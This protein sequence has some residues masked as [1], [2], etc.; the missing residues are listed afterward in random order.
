MRK[1]LQHVIRHDL[2]DKRA[3]IRRDKAAGRG[4]LN[5]ETLEGRTLLAGGLVVGP[6]E[7]LSHAVGDQAETAIAINPTNP[8]NIVA[9]SNEV[10]ASTGLFEGISNDGGLTWL[11]KNVATGSDGLQAACCD[12]SLAF[13]RFGNLFLTYIT[14]DVSTAVVALSTDG[15]QTFKAIESVGAQDQPK[16]ATGPGNLAG[17]QSV[18]IEYLDSSGNIAAVSANTS[19]LGK[20][21]AFTSVEEAPGLGGNFGKLSIGPKGQVMLTYQDNT[22][23]GGPSSIFVN[24]DPDGVGGSGFGPSIRVTGTNVG[25]FDYITAQPNRSIDAE[26]GLAY[27]NSGGAHNGRVYMV[28]TD[29]A[30]AGLN[31]PT[32]A[33]SNTF[34]L[35]RYSDDNGTTW[36]NPLRV[37]DNPTKNSE[38][39]PRIAVDPVTG[40]VGFSW[41]DCRHDLG[42]GGAGDTDGKPNDQPEFFATV[43]LDGGLTF[44][45]NVQ[46]SA[47]PSDALIAAGGSGDNGFDFGDYTGLSFYNNVLRPVWADNSPQLPGIP[48]RPNLDIASAPVNVE[49]LSVTPQPFTPTENKLFTGTVATFKD[50]SHPGSPASNYVAQINWGDGTVTNGAVQSLGVDS[51]S[52]IGSKLY[53]EGG[54]YPV[55]VTVTAAGGITVSANETVSVTDLPLVATGTT[56]SL[57]EGDLFNG[58]LATFTDTN[59]TPGPTSDYTATIDWGDGSVITQGVINPGPSGGFTVTGSHSYGGGTHAAQ[60]TIKDNGGAS[61]TATSNFT[62]KDAALTTSPVAISGVEGTQFTGPVATFTDSDPRALSVSYYHATIDWGDGTPLDTGSI[63]PIGSGAFQVVGTHLARVG[64]HTVHVAITDSDVSSASTDSTAV[65]AA[66]PISGFA[67]RIGSNEGGMFSGIL[68]VFHDT[69]LFAVATD[70]E[71]KIIWGDGSQTDSKTS[72]DAQITNNGD[73]E[74]VLSGQ[75]SYQVGVYQTKV[76]LYEIAAT[77]DNIV[78]GTATVVDAPLSGTASPLVVT[79]GKTVQAVVATFTDANPSAQFSDFDATISWGDGVVTTGTVSAAK[80]SGFQVT[81]SH[82]YAIVGTYAVNV[83]ITDHGG[84]AG[85]TGIGKAETELNGTAVVTEAPLTPGGAEIHSSERASTGTVVA[86]TFTD[87]NVMSNASEFTAT[88]AWGDGQTSPGQV[89]SDGPPGSYSVTGSHVYANAGNYTVNVL[90]VSSSGGTTTTQGTATVDDVIL[91]L[92]GTLL[93]SS[94]TSK[95]GDWITSNQQPTFV[96]TAEP[97]S[98][99]TIYAVP[100]GQTG[101]FPIGQGGVDGIGNWTVTVSPLANGSY[102]IFAQAHDSANR[103]S[104]EL[105]PLLSPAP[106]GALVIATVGPKVSSL[107]LDPRTDTFRIDFQAGADLLDMSTLLNPANYVLSLPTRRG[108]QIF[109]VASV[110]VDPSSPTAILVKFNAGRMRGNYIIT[111]SGNGVTDQAGNPLDERFFLNFP[112]FAQSPGQPF[113]AQV[114]TNGR[115]ASAPQPFVPA[116][117]LAAANQFERFIGRA[118]RFPRVFRL[119]RFR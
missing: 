8:L 40:V 41:Y 96:G 52:V 15:G 36:S 64:T 43:S 78:N 46:V 109:G 34:I 72:T 105:T 71:A 39:F 59:P 44:Q 97:N 56:Q 76:N 79:E 83:L 65:I 84:A 5:V 9:T 101:G 12:D 28:Y 92:K 113:V 54:S 99:V 90:V 27:D 80:D 108:S 37:S 117:Q 6:I 69:N 48:D 21:G 11:S 82:A 7:N 63:V 16:V 114:S 32:A 25:G 42:T 106:G 81:G 100:T 19:G 111:I 75:H 29:A 57:N 50:T 104:S 103:P 60:I 14:S 66:A 77:S 93:R 53:L 61:V 87:A 102:Q 107:T 45:P 116:D 33:S 20:V 23:S 85:S 73:G 2:R 95:S 70:F 98:I 35:E 74:F 30:V 110:T 17:S 67:Y 91:P 55:S 26:A 89:L 88:I 119:R 4:R 118:G 58:V 62:V 1:H 86:G 24:L 115:T 47:G 22:G 31:P 51:F 112:G 38:F 49:I 13:D 94:D 18:W 10:D 68:G 3:K